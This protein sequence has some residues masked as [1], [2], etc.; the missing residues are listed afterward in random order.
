MTSRFYPNHILQKEYEDLNYV[1]LKI[2]TKDDAIKILEIFVW[3]FY[4]K[5]CAMTERDE[6]WGQSL[7]KILHFLK[8]ST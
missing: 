6:K 3:Q 1:D 5:E 8:E 4:K 7:N 2:S